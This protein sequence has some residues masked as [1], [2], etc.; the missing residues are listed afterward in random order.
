MQIGD[1]IIYDNN[2]GIIIG[3]EENV[4]RKKNVSL[5]WKI[6]ITHINNNEFSFLKIGDII[7]LLPFQFTL[8]PIKPYERE[9][10][11]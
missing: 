4:L 2:F 11:K 3:R 9:N 10:R 1:E 7:Y 8:K 5:K 6:K